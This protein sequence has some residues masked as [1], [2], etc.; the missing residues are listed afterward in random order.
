MPPNGIDRRRVVLFGGLAYATGA[1]L[2][3]AQ[4]QSAAAIP[5]GGRSDQTPGEV[6]RL[7]AEV[8]TH[9]TIDLPGRTLRFAATAGALPL[10]GENNA[11]RAEL[12]FVAFQLEDA[13]AAHR[14]VTFAFNGGPGFASGWLN[15]GAVGPWRISV[16]ADTIAA[17][18]SPDTIPNAETWL[19]FTDLVFIDP[20]ATGYSRVLDS[21]ERVRRRLFSVEGDIAYLADAI[22]HWVDRF[23]RSVSPK[24]LLGESYGGFRVPRI[25][26]ALAAS[27]GTGVSGLV[28]ISPKLDF[29]DLSA[30]FNPLSYV[31]RLPSMTA[32]ARAEQGSVTRAQLADVEGYARGD[33]LVDVVRGET[34]P[35]TIARRSA[36]VAAFT[37]L[38]PALVRR[39]HGLISN[40][41]FLHELDRARGRLG[42]IYD[43]TVTT[44]DPFP[45]DVMGDYPDPVLEALKAPV[46]SAMVEIYQNRLNWRPD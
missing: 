30:A 45:L 9:H 38:D 40:D 31:T 7:P 25:A 26:R 2:G 5:D 28:L 43:A 14:P 32:T 1:L 22:R 33:Y 46:S 17:S 37:G 3:E 41:V 19:D 21:S 10:S 11:P 16:A 29:G 20:A 34:D 36:R 42:S 18:A 24:Y 15:V 39:C 4:A 8:T 27:Q 12:A 44:A 6:R 23:D 13:N 35:E